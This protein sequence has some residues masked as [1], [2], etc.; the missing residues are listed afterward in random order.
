MEVMQMLDKLSMESKVI[1]SAWNFILLLELATSNEE[2]DDFATA[3]VCLHL[4][5]LVG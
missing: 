2:S 5:L 1:A 3:G 4:A